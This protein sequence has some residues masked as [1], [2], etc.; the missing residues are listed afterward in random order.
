MRRSSRVCRSRRTEAGTVDVRPSGSA[1]GRYSCGRGSCIRLPCRDTE[2]SSGLDAERWI[3][4][5]FSTRHGAAETVAEIYP[6]DALVSAVVGSAASGFAA[7]FL[8]TL[9][10]DVNE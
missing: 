6:D 7:V 1:G 4:M 2:T 5:V 8:S 3:G 9:T 10:D